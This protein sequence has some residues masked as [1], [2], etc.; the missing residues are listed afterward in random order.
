[1]VE[2]HLGIVNEHNEA[3]G[4][5]RR[6]TAHQ[7]GLW[8]RGATSFSSDGTLMVQRRVHPRDAYPHAL[9]SPISEHLRTGGSYPDG[10]IRGLR[11]ELGVEQ[12]GLHRLVQFSPEI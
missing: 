11:E 6:Q 12:I 9:D 3:M 2:E 4:R 1:M 7:S 5:K 10:A 8:H